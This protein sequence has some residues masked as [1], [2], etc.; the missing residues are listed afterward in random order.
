[1]LLRGSAV[2]LLTTAL[3]F[4]AD[5]PA[6]AFDVASVKPSKPDTQPNSNFPLGPGDVYVPNGGLFSASGLPL[7]T[8]IFFAYKFI[9][10]QAQALIPQLPEWARNDKFD[11]QA[12]AS[13]NPGKDDM[14][15]MMR[16]LL[17]DRFKFAIH[18]ETKDVP[19]F[20][21]VLAKPGKLGPK[22]EPHAEDPPCE[23]NQ[24]STPPP[25]GLALT[26]G[27]P[28]LCNGI[29]GM[30]TAAENPRTQRI[31]A[32]NVTLDF[33]ADAL[34]A[35]SNLGRPMV[36]KT[37]MDGRFDFSLE[38]TVEIPNQP[39]NADS[40][41][42]DNAGVTLQQALRDQLGIKLQADKAPM[43]V[44]VFDHA[45]HPSDN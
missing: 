40:E 1:M 42:P 15:L 9:G 26:R 23:V 11:I 18:Y 12:R 29:F 14:R 22:I 41:P 34:S 27:L 16:T 33:I 5:V 8:Y 17:A 36:N 38:W 30:P 39:A 4:A 6:P 32:R 43:K 7:V 24:S 35:G 25:G 21:W 45:E 28:V 2:A 3:A 31:A 10:N 44:A 19:V 37:G 20:A 13:G